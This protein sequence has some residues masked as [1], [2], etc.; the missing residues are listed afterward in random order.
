MKHL[1]SM[2]QVII[3]IQKRG[4]QTYLTAKKLDPIPLELN[5]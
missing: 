1:K 5:T 3:S 2:R 4:T